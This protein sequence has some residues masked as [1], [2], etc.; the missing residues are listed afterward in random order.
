[1]KKKR[2]CCL[3]PRE[4]VGSKI[5]TIMKLSFLMTFVAVFSVSANVNTFSQQVS[6]RSGEAELRE[7]FR[8]LKEQT[9]FMITYSDSRLES[10]SCRIA[11]DVSGAT[12]E[13]ALDIV[14]KGLPY[15]YKVEDRRVMIIPQPVQQAPEAAPA[16]GRVRDEKGQPVV[17]VSVVLKGSTSTGTATDADGR[18]SLRVAPGSTLIF[19]YVGMNTQEVVWSGQNPLEVTMT[20][21]VA[22]IDQVVVTGITTTDKRLFSGA[23]DH[24]DAEK[25]MLSGIADVSRS[26]EGRSAGVMVQNV[27]GTFGTAPKIRIRGA[28]SIFGNSKPLWVVDGVIVEDVANISS[29]ALSSGDAITLIGN[30]IAGLNADDIETFD[31][32]KDGSATSIYGAR[33]MSGVIVITTKKGRPGTAKFTYTG[34]FTTRLTPSYREFNIMNSQDQMG[35]YKELEEKGYLNYASVINAS[36]SGVYGQMY[37]LIQSYNPATGFGLPHTEEAMNLYLRN[38]EMKNTDWFDELFNNSIMMNHS[39][40]FSQGSDKASSYVSMSFMDDPGWYRRGDVQRYT[41]NANVSYKLFDNLTLSVL[42]N[43]SYRKQEAPGTLSETTDAVGGTVSRNFDIN[44]YSFALNT[45]RTMGIEDTFT[46]NYAPFNILD[47]LDRNYMDLDVFDTKFQAELKWDILP[48]LSV[49]ALGAVKYQS[50]MTQHY[51]MDD[52]NQA[53]AYRAMQTTVI[54]DNNTYIYDDPEILNDEPITV[55]PEGGFYNVD[56][57]KMISYDF[58]TTLRYNKIFRDVHNLDFYAG[59]EINSL[60]RTGL[61]FDGVGMQY[62]NGEIANFDYRWFKKMNQDNSNYFWLDHSRNRGAAFFGTANYAYKSKYILNLTLRYEGSN[63]LGRARSSRWLPT[64]NVSGAWNAHSED[65]FQKYTDVVSHLKVRG[66]YSLTAQPGP[67]YVSNAQVII[68]NY[69]PWRFGALNREPGLQV[70]QLENSE[71]TYEKQHEL[72]F[73]I[74]VGFLDNRINLVFDWYKRDMYDLIGLVSTMGVGGQI[75]KDANSATMKSHGIEFTLSTRNIVDREFTWTTDFT[76]SWNKSKITDMLSANNIQRLMTGRGFPLVGYTRSSLFSLRFMG[77]TKEGLPT[78]WWPRE[79]KDPI[80]GPG[81]YGDLNFQYKTNNNIEFLKY[82]GMIEPPVTGGFGNTFSWKGLRLNVFMTY[83]FGNHIR[84]DNIFKSRYT[85]MDAMQREFINRW[86]VPGDEL[87]TN[88]PVIP[89]TRQQRQYGNMNYA[90]NAYNYSD[91]RVASGDFIR[92]KEISLNYD[93]SKRITDKLRMS[94]LSL[95]LSATN[96]FLIYSDK[97]LNGQ[98]PEF[99]RSGGVAVPMSKQFTMTLRMGF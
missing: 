71:L 8:S 80:I 54:R 70:N 16:E 65:F 83:A 23:A 64:W 29:D 93:F 78:F 87:K 56:E 37:K 39:V 99:F 53:Q 82:E 47:E 88:I 21:Q 81:S 84:L 6:L 61:G 92:M 75:N 24:I 45:S 42:G 60:N 67:S 14:L 59:M 30:A 86:T 52:S 38:A 26:L 11:A 76:F 4:R 77:L 5:I 63:R 96:L 10:E 15:T 46:R 97:K 69:S 13:Q 27:S 95:K 94:N 91:Q 49:T 58:R 22:E 66:S 20:E 73:G 50:T 1:M 36:N 85:D 40:S 68:G 89:D 2:Q 44:P 79:G 19:S 3:F 33:A 55:L 57:Y 7:V 43:G 48:G 41:L 25:I 12:L 98:D 35:I 51:I 28:T 32:L 34:E 18:F 9:G 74:D 31:V 62:S 90:F 72:D 17:G